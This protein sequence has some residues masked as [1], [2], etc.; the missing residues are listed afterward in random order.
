MLV[1]AGPPPLY[2]NYWGVL[3]P[4]PAC[5]PDWCTLEEST[6]TSRGLATPWEALFDLRDFDYSAFT[7]NQSMRVGTVT[8][9]VKRDSETKVETGFFSP[10]SDIYASAVPVGASLTPLFGAVEIAPVRS[11]EDASNGTDVDGDGLFDSCDNCIEVYNPS[12]SD[13]NFDGYGNACDGDLDNTGEVNMQDVALYIES[14]GMDVCAN[15]A[16]FNPQADLKADGCVN[17]QDFDLFMAQLESGVVGPSA[18]TCAGA[19]PG[20]ADYPCRSR[21]EDADGDGVAD[22]EDRC[23]GFWNPGGSAEY[24]PPT[25]E[26]GAAPEVFQF[27]GFF[28]VTDAAAGR[29]VTLEAEGQHPDGLGFPIFAVLGNNSPISYLWNL[30]GAEAQGWWSYFS[31]S[32]AV[33]FTAPRDQPYGVH[34]VSVTTYSVWGEA[35]T[36]TVPVLVLP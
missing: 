17:D 13:A 26:I 33:T 31:A 36:V 22:V 14:S 11:C 30:D 19:G 24:S 34:N 16:N 8:F 35:T 6:E 28:V 5:T 20:D 4:G 10:V 7:A 15:S 3:D 12:Q 18:L 23:E 32:S 25:L 1:Q 27:W 9:S 29:T 21:S 2:T